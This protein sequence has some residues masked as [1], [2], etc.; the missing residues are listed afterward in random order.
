MQQRK[1]R[2]NKQIVGVK[3]LRDNNTHD[4][5]GFHQLTIMWAEFWLQVYDFLFESDHTWVWHFCRSKINSEITKQ[6]ALPNVVVAFGNGSGFM[7]MWI[8]V[9]ILN[10]KCCV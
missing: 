4:S 8:T 7:G 6:D 5:Q 10:F 9:E 2:I 3:G 1:G